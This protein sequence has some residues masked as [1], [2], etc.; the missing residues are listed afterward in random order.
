[1]D[2]AALARA[3]R[4]GGH[5]DPRRPAVSED[6]HRER[7]LADEQDA[8]LYPVAAFTGLRLGELPRCAGGR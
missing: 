1:V 8:A 5:R 2:V 7:R 4:V 6:E 3:A